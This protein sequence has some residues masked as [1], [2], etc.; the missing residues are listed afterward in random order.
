MKYYHCG[1]ENQET[2]EFSCSK[3]RHSMN[4]LFKNEKCCRLYAKYAVFQIIVLV[5]FAKAIISFIL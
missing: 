2:S 5:K 4:M 3:I 1:Q